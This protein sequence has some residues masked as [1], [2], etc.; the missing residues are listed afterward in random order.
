MEKGEQAVLRPASKTQN[1][2]RRATPEGPG[3]EHQ[4]AN[5]GYG[6]HHPDQ[7]TLPAVS[8]YE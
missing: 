7:A 8:Q 4:Q 3:R 5:R 2:S 1:A 6:R